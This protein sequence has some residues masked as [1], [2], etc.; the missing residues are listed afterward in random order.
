[1]TKIISII[2]NGKRL[3]LPV[4]NFVEKLDTKTQQILKGTEPNQK[5]EKKEKG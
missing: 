3:D 1:M 5:I 4:K 2:S